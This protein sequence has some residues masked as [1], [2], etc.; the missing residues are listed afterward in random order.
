[1]HSSRLLSAFDVR[2]AGPLDAEAIQRLL[3]HAWRVFQG[4]EVATWMDCVQSGSCWVAC[5]G[6][7]IKGHLA[8]LVR[9]FAIAKVVSASVAN[10]ESA[11]EFAAAMLPLVSRTLRMREITGIVLVGDAPWLTEVLEADG[12]QRRETVITYGRHATAPVS[13]SGNAIVAIEHADAS[14]VHEIAAIDWRVFGPLWHK[15]AE[16]LDRVVAGGLPFMVATH[17]GC[18]VGYQWHAHADSH[19]HLNRLAVSPEW[20]DRGVGTRLLTEALAA[21]A[22]VG[23]SWV[24]LNTQQS[25]VRSRRLYERFGFEPVGH[26]A[27]LVWKP[28][29]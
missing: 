3:G 15:P 23:V 25:N 24:T 11:A 17:A 5:H 9:P 1:M 2:P 20:Q 13:I 16:D 10:G 28:L 12:F 19:G 7:E 6:G 21:M 26:P 22:C 14:M 18:I 8:A 27:P 4:H 29:P